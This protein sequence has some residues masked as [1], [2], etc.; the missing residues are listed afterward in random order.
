MGQAVGFCVLP[1]GTFQ[2]HQNCL[3]NVSFVELVCT[4]VRKTGRAGK[5]ASAPQI[6]DAFVW[7]LSRCSFNKK[8]HP[9]PTFWF[10]NELGKNKT[11]NEPHCERTLRPFFL[12]I[13]HTAF[14]TVD[15]ALEILVYFASW[16][17]AYSPTHSS[18]RRRWRW[19]TKQQALV[20]GF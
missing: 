13:L 12:L 19:R 6:I 11:E 1:R 8:V 7:S 16:R 10:R 9:S 15:F 2:R 5:L 4:A 14:G 20:F 3:K 18:R 17:C